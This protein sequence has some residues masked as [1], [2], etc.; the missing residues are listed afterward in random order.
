[1]AYQGPE[2]QSTRPPTQ[3]MPP[4]RPLTQPLQPT[5]PLTEPPVPGY[6]RPAGYQRLTGPDPATLLTW[7]RHGRGRRVGAA[8]IDYLAVAVFLVVPHVGGI[9]W[10]VAHVVNAY[11]EGRTGQTLG[12]KAVGIYTIRADNG[13]FVGG[14]V[15]VGRKLLHVLDTLALLTGWIVGL[16]TNRTYAD[17]IIGTVVVRPPDYGPSGRS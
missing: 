17:M 8:V 5:R 15:G 3:P 14:P 2:Y 9:L 4:T 6:L 7:N 10:L 12:K 11:F 13:E 1:M 16:I